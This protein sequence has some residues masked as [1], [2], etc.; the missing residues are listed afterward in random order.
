V[1]RHAGVPV[2]LV[3][4]VGR[5]LPARMWEALV[6]RLDDEAGDPWDADD[7]IV[8]LDLVDQLC[9]IHGPETVADGLR[10]VDCPVTPELFKPTA[11]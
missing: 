3:G 10:R 2:W 9:G 5:L 6:R 1:A 4:G 8:P 11:F 7:E